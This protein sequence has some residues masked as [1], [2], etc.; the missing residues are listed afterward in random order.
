MFHFMSYFYFSCLTC[1][2]LSDFN[3]P[4]L[5]LFPVL[6]LRLLSFVFCVLVY[7][8]VSL[9]TPQSNF[10]SLT[11]IYQVWL[12][13]IQF[14]FYFFILTIICP[15]LL[16]FPQCYFYSP[17]WL[18]SS[19]D[20]YLIA[21]WLLSPRATFSPV[22]SLFLSHF[23]NSIWLSF[24]V[25]L[26]CSSMCYFPASISVLPAN[27]AFTPASACQHCGQQLLTQSM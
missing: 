26:L 19:S 27:P 21:I 22:L 8:P 13:F 5:L 16:L 9:L 11:F 15:V 7:F 14:D 10:L 24:P 20:F 3:L 18:Y 17:V 2:S 12:L 23:I 1:I 6:L 4:V 25:W